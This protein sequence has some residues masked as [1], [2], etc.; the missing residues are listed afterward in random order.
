MVEVYLEVGNI[1]SAS[2]S[3]EVSRSE[4]RSKGLSHVFSLTSQ[5]STV[6]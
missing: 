6:T 2:G 1:L 3:L 4:R 5:V